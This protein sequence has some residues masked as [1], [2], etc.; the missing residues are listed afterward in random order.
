MVRRAY[1]SRNAQRSART[2]RLA[3]IVPAEPATR[4]GGVTMAKRDRFEEM[5]SFRA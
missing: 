4:T 5:D 3:S 1:A 2:F